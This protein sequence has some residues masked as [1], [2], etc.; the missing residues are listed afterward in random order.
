MSRPG[1]WLV[2]CSLVLPRTPGAGEHVEV[3]SPPTGTVSR[4]SARPWEAHPAPHALSWQSADSDTVHTSLVPWV[5]TSA[6]PP[7]LPGAP[8][9]LGGQGSRGNPTQLSG[10]RTAAQALLSRGPRPSSGPPPQGGWSCPGRGGGGEAGIQ[11]QGPEPP[12][13]QRPGRLPN[14]GGVRRKEREGGRAAG[15]GGWGLCPG[16]PPFTPS[17]SHAQYLSS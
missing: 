16:A 12:P 1:S 10:P 7:R 13:P 8:W 4:A 5:P 2:P 11:G 6:L 3:C 17:M 15:S 14:G 9:C